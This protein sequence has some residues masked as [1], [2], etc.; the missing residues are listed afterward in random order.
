MLMYVLR[1]NDISQSAFLDLI[2]KKVGLL[3][4][5]KLQRIFFILH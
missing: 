3:I 1:T 4:K 2:I 5:F